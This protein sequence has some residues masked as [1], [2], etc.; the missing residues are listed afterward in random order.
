MSAI[1]ARSAHIL[2]AGMSDPDEPVF[3]S[4]LRVSA[5]AMAR[6][7]RDIA[8]DATG[9]RVMRSVLMKPE[10]E[11]YVPRLH[12]RIERLANAAAGG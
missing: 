11:A 8:A 4:T 6:R 10:H 9:A 2:Q 1:D 5:D 3:V 12:E 7:H